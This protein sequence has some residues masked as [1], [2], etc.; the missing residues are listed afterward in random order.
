MTTLDL[1]RV[2][3]LEV[4]QKLDELLK[5]QEQLYD[6]KWEATTEARREYLKERERLMSEIDEKLEPLRKKVEEIEKTFD[7][8]AEKISEAIAAL[9]APEPMYNEDYDT[10]LHCDLTGLLLL[11]CDDVIK[12]ENSGN[13]ILRWVLPWPSEEKAKESERV[14]ELPY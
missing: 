10:I 4:R 11:E 5:K 7:E 2:P 13:V 9:G 6:Q 8:E 12:D 1:S 3:F 14:P